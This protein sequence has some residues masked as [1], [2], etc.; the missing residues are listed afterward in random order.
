VQKVDGS[1]AKKGG[2]MEIIK[3]LNQIFLCEYLHFLLVLFKHLQSLFFYSYFSFFLVVEGGIK[4]SCITR[5]TG[6]L[7]VLRSNYEI[8]HEQIQSYEVC[9]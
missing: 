8:V 1:K 3:K 2:R 9:Y 7:F 6:K 5:K 4:K